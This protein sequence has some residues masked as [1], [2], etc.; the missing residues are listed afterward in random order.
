MI[1][2]E[3]LVILSRDGNKSGTGDRSSS[4]TLKRKLQEWVSKC[5]VDDGYCFQGRPYP[6]RPAR[7]PTVVVA[8]LNDE[9]EDCIQLHKPALLSHDPSNDE[10]QTKST[11]LWEDLQEKE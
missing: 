11:V 8:P 5:E 9:V 6:R 10:R 1:E 7:A 2:N 4:T 3:M